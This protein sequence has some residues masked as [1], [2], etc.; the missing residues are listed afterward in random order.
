MGRAGVELSEP[1]RNDGASPLGTVEGGTRLEDETCSKGLRGDIGFE[2]GAE[3]IGVA[4]TRGGVIA[5]SIPSVDDIVASGTVEG[6]T[7]P[8]D[9][10]ELLM[11]LELLKSNEGIVKS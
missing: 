6:G 4:G 8:P 2:P 5:A 3:S 9:P 11:P 7:S 1:E 10:T